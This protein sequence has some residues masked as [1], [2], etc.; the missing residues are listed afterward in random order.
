MSLE[1]CA[2]DTLALAVRFDLTGMACTVFSEEIEFAGERCSG[3]R[4]GRVSEWRYPEGGHC[5]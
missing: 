4:C 2:D 3:W 5:Y 1:E